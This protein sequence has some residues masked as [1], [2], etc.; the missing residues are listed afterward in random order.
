MRGTLDSFRPDLRNGDHVEFR[1]MKYIRDMISWWKPSFQ[2]SGVWFCVEVHIHNV[3]LYEQ[4]QV[5]CQMLANS[6][7]LSGRV[8]G[9][10]DSACAILQVAAA[11]PGCEALQRS[12]EETCATCL[13]YLLSPPSPEFLEL[14]HGSLAAILQVPPAS[15]QT[16]SLCAR[17]I[18]SHTTR[19]RTAV[20]SA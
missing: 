10:Q 16:L 18:R 9:V 13:E 20:L 2:C 11:L 17:S 15:P 1:K 19:R 5:P 14:D 7:E 3:C 12:C 4:R 6:A 8:F